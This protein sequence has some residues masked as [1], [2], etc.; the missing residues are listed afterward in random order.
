V[1]YHGTAAWPEP[2]SFDALLDAPTAA[3]PALTPYLV[4]FEYLLHD[5]SA[6]SDEELRAGAQTA[7]AKLVTVCLKHAWSGAELLGVLRR[8]MDVAREAALAPNGLEALAQVIR[9]ILEVAEE[10]EEEALQE[11]LDRGLAPDAKDT[12]MTIAQRYI[13][14]GRQQGIEQGIEQGSQRILLRLLRKRF[15]DTVDPG[16]EAR[17]AKASGAEI[18]TW[19][20]RVLSATTLDEIFAG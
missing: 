19:S 6:I 13:E 3:R 10:I 1:L 15:G 4:R 14:Q 9:Y 8:W 17:I 12:I 16:V 7:L 11:L 20:D 18:E 5:L 2:R